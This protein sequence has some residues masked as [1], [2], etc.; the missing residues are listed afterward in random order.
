M[1][2]PANVEPNGTTERIR[3]LEVER[4]LATRFAMT[5]ALEERYL[6]LSA[7]VAGERI[8]EAERLLREWSERHHW[9][10]DRLRESTKR[11]LSDSA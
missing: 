6:R 7:E 3:V 9:E 1:T 2:T 10:P 8:A 11:F 4:D 5:L